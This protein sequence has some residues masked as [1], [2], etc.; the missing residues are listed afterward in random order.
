MPRAILFGRLNRIRSAH[1]LINHHKKTIIMKLKEI[2]FIG[3]VVKDNLFG[4][5]LGTVTN[6]TNSSVRVRYE[7]SKC[8]YN[9]IKIEGFV[10]D[11]EPVTPHLLL[12]GI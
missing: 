7:Y 12:T 1:T 8:L 10:R 11:L 2:Y 3:Q 4:G 5:R 6:V 9:D